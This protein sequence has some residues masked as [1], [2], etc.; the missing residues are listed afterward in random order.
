VRAFLLIRYP[1]A[2]GAT[3]PLVSKCRGSFA[4]LSWRLRASL[5]T[6]G[7]SIS[8]MKHDVQICHTS[9]IIAGVKCEYT[10]IGCRI[11]TSRPASLGL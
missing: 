4:G 1:P 3:T 5:G 8:C 7:L 11:L 2:I 6:D 10:A 9:R